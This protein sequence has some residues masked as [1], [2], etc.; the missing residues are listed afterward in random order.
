MLNS[1]PPS[2]EPFPHQYVDRRSGAVCNERLYSDALVR[3]LYGTVREHAP[4]VFRLATS[5]HSTALLGW[6]NYDLPLGGALAGNRA[7][8]AESGLNLSECVAAPHALQTVRQLFERQIRFWE[9]RPLPDDLAAVV[10]PADARV[11][12]GSLALTSALFLKGK[13]FDL[14]E[15]LGR[16]K[17][18]WLRAFRQADW[19]IFRLTPDKYHYNHLPV[20]GVVKDFYEV[21]G[22]SHACNPAAIVAEV[23]PYSKNTRTVTILNTDVPGG[24]QVGLVAMLEITALMIGAVQQCYSSV[25]YQ[26]P[27]PLVPGMRLERGCVKSLYRP[28]SSTDVLLFEPG[29]VQF[30]EDLWRNQHRQDVQSRFSH[31]FGRPLV[32]TEVLVRSSIARRLAGAASAANTSTKDT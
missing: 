4:S 27:R 31:G 32:E 22:A 19:A 5:A 9:C 6:L 8:L 12:L 2:F 18:A 26:Q 13:F 23:T 16:D 29:R 14:E 11:L 21:R 28:G 30:D 7:F 17:L 25:R 20:T 3:R 10:A 24:T 15:L 1:L